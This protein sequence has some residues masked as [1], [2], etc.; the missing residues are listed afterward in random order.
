MEILENIDTEKVVVVA[1]CWIV[2]DTT[3]YLPTP[4]IPEDADLL[5]SF[6]KIKAKAPPSWKSY[7]IE[8]LDS[9]GIFFSFKLKL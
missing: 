7:Q 1:D 9:F 6:L 3:F 5:E 4:H 8:L 2:G